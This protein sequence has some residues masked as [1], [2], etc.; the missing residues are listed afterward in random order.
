MEFLTA[1]EDDRVKETREAGPHWQRKAASAADD[2]GVTVMDDDH[3][4]PLVVNPAWVLA[5]VAAK[6]TLLTLHSREIATGYY[7][8]FGCPTCNLDDGAILA[9]WPCPTLRALAL[10]WSDH[11]DFD[12]SWHV[13]TPVR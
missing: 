12:P 2:P 8:G 1:R 7:D 13:Q 5:D 9:G 10:T 3:S 4:Y 6:R 11:P